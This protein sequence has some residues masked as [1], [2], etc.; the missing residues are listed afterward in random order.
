MSLGEEQRLKASRAKELADFA[1]FVANGISTKELE[2]ADRDL[3]AALAKVKTATPAEK[4]ALQKTQK[5]W[6]IYRDADLALYEHAFG[7]KQGVD[8][9]HA[10]VFVGLESHRAK[11]CAFP[12][13]GLE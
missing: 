3:A 12:S 1:R 5:T 9:V 2:A 8:R 10:T 4:E 11:D 7:A 6:T 13:A